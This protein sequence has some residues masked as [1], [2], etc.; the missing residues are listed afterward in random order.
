M[1]VMARRRTFAA[2]VAAAVALLSA[3]SGSVTPVPRLLR[4]R[5]VALSLA[6]A[7]FM[8]GVHLNWPRR[9]AEPPDA[10]PPAAV[11]L[12]LPSLRVATPVTRHRVA[13]L[14]QSRPAIR[15]PPV[16]TA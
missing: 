6:H 5:P 11:R 7:P 8:H 15:G 2:A 12:V 10:Q 4:D 9:A 14:R 1:N 3:P 13:G 16:G